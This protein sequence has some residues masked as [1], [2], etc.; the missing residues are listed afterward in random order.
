MPVNLSI[1]NVPDAVVARLRQRAEE[2]RRSLQGELLTI[3][4]RAA[5]SERLTIG[6]LHEWGRSQAFRSACTVVDDLRTMREART[7]HLM[8]VLDTT[9]EPSQKRA[10]GGRRRR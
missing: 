1:K 8:Q 9:A 6:E 2:N 7:N 5:D 3:V 10:A 4:E